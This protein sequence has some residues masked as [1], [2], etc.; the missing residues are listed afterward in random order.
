MYPD[1]TKDVPKMYQNGSDQLEV[2]P[3]TLKNV[4]FCENQ[5]IL[6]SKEVLEHRRKLNRM[7]S[8]HIYFT[9]DLYWKKLRFNILEFIQRVITLM[10]LKK[11][12]LIIR[13]I[14]F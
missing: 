7:F 10:E 9:V 14:V 12:R 3:K 1:I 2:E 11:V 13:P 6:W 5:E 8:F 4:Y